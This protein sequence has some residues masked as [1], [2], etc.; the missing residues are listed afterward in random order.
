[1]A[2]TVEDG[3]GVTGAN[4]YVSVADADA[5]FA[6]VG[7]PALWTAA[8]SGEKE[9]ALFKGTQYIEAHYLWATGGISSTTQG[10]GWPRSSAEDRYGRTLDSDV[11]PEVVKQAT[12]EA[13]LRSMTEDL[14][15]DE[16]QR[17]IKERVEGA[18]EIQYADDGDSTTHYPMID[19]LLTGLAYSNDAQIGVVR[20]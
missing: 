15:A 19:Q 6:L 9:Q 20:G 7:T 10:L 8:T 17:V 4:S 1:V 3:T 18:V 16:S 5:Y 12:C 14:L 13:A 11:V 2:F